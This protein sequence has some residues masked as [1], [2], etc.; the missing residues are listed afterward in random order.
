MSGKS[1]SIQ[2][3]WLGR[4]LLALTGGDLTIRLWDCQSNDTYVLPLPDMAEISFHSG[5]EHFTTLAYQK[6]LL[7]AAT[8]LGGIAFWR[9]DGK[10]SG[11]QQPSSNPEEDWHF[12]GLVGLSGNSMDHSAWVSGL[13]Y[14]HTGSTLYQIT[15][16]EPF[17]VFH[18]EVRFFLFDLHI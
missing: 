10:N 16:Q 15:Q 17:V 4:N 12:I 9:C 3:T 1:R 18:N 11:E 7:A 8:N 2:L 14:I 5:A 6:P 13:L